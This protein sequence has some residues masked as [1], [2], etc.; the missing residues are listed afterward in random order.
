M[1]KV[2]GEGEHKLI[3]FIRK[4]RNENETYCLY[5][6]DADLIMLALGTQLEKFYILRE[7]PMDSVVSYYVINIG[8]FRKEL[9]D[10]LKWGEKFQEKNGVNDFIFM[11]FMVGNDFLPH[12]PGI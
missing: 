11:C 4:Y 1:K 5:G 9:C 3:N 7:E 6:M 10:T 8:H 2:A 12:I